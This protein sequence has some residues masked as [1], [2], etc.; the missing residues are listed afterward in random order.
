ML[1]ALRELA[2]GMLIILFLI[3]EP[4]GL[5]AV[6]RKLRLWLTASKPASSKPASSKPGD[7]SLAATTNVT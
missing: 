1:S 5:M 6:F 3:F 2:F 4:L 7:K